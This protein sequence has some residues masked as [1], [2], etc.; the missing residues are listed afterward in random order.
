MTESIYKV[1]LHLLIVAAGARNANHRAARAALDAV[2][3]GHDAILQ[4]VMANVIALYFDAQTAVA[5]NL[6]RAS[7]EALAL[8]TLE[9]TQK[10]EARGLAPLSDTLQ[11]KTSWAKAALERARAQ[12]VLEKALVALKLAVGLDAGRPLVL[13]QEVITSIPGVEANQAEQDLADWLR[14]AELHHPAI[15]AAR[16]QL[17]SAQEKLIQT[18]AEGLPTLDFNRNEYIN[19]RPNQ[20]LSAT[21]TKETT[22]SLALNI[23]LFDGFARTYK[24]RGAQASI[25]I[26][27]AELEDTQR[28]ILSE[29]AKSY[30]DALASVHTLEAAHTLHETASISLNNMQRKYDLGLADIMEILNV[31]AALIDAKQ[32][33]IRAQAEWRSAR[34]RLL[35]N[36]GNAG[37]VNM[38]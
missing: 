7:S 8:Q 22:S 1:F 12:G 2:L 27:Q 16:F 31:Q 10:R 33:E 3:Y 35:A 21:Q 11:A 15:L 30:A 36:A 20:G 6:A 28:Q 34:L 4:K 18:R 19:G 13:E 37:L 17:S 32:E 25:A 26:R 9:S 23:P 5:N 38:Q 14:L 24:V 29:V